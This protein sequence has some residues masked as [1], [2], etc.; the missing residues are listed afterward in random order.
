MSLLELF[1]HVDDFRKAFQPYWYKHLHS[2]GERMRSSRLSPSEIMT[3][4]ILFHKS[5]YRNFKAFYT[6]Y[7]MVH[8]DNEFKGL[9]SYNRFVELMPSG[10]APLLFYLLQCKGSCSGIAFVDATSIKVCHTHWPT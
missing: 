8:P 3:L 9:V 5:H 1:C 2:S 7:V 6:Q 4:L 10:T